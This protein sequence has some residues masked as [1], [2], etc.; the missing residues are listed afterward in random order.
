MRRLREVLDEAEAFVTRIPT[1]KAGLLFLK[2][3]HVVQPNPDR[4]QE[5]QTHAGQ[6]SPL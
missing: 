5:Y 3:G 2:G 4:L 1:E 6:K